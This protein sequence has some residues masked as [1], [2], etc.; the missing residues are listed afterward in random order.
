MMTLISEEIYYY[1]IYICSTEI[2]Q[3]HDTAINMYN[4]LFPMLVLAMH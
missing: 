4:K 2:S 1:N 3:Q